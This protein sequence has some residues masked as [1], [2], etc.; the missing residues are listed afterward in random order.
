MKVT[1][2]VTL[3]FFV[4][5]FARAEDEACEV[6]DPEVPVSS[7]ALLQV[8]AN[9]ETPESTNALLQ[10]DDSRQ[11]SYQLQ[12]DQDGSKPCA[13]LKGKKYTSGKEASLDEAGY[14]STAKLCCHHEMSLFVR[15]EIASQGFDVCDLSD[16]HGFVHWYDC[17]NDKKTYAEMR[18]EIAGVMKTACPWLGHLPKCPWKDPVHC[19]RIARKCASPA[20]SLAGSAAPLNAQGYTAVALKCCHHDMAKFIRRE[21]DRQ[22]FR[23]C[24][25][26]SFQGFLH[27][28]D[29]A[30]DDQ[31]YE[32][33]KEGLVIARSGLPPM[34]PW[35]GS[36]G[37][38]C[39][40]KGHNCPVVE[41]PEPAAHRRRVACR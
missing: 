23:V 3:L 9:K 38:A 24:D 8:Q 41:V 21:I 40:P 22:G 25:E 27:W 31:T 35:L 1:L 39:P 18:K 12:G 30:D 32:D 26:G 20:N 34:C 7:S 14:Q 10:N 36:V 5:A 29:C 33:L 15:R 19:G 4:S 11:C 37:Q 6:P 2:R 13:S 16:L 17:S 28:F